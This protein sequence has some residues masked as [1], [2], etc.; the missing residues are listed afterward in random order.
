MKVF[1]KNRSFGFIA[2]LIFLSA[3]VIGIFYFSNNGH[4]DPG[5]NVGVLIIGLAEPQ[6]MNEGVEGWKNYLS[7]YANGALAMVPGI[8]LD[9][10]SGPLFN[11]TLA[12]FE[13]RPNSLRARL[14]PRF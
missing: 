7:G 13:V 8:D 2:A 3:F 12:I 11:S 9:I 6:Y 14:I 4:A 1:K 10:L 5:E